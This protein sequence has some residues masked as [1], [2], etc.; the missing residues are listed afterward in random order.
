MYFVDPD[1]QVFFNTDASDYSIGGYM[2]QIFDEVENPCAFVSERD[3]NSLVHTT[4]GSLK[5]FLYLP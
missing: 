5:Y 4:E 2:F 1:A 3:P